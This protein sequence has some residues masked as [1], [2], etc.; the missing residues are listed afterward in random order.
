AFCRCGASNNKPYC[1][2]QH[3]KIGFQS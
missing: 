1:D 2:G 3:K